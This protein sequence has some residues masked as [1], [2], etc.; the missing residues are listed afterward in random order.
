[1]N[2]FNTKTFSYVKEKNIIYEADQLKKDNIRN[3]GNTNTNIIG[4]DDGIWC[5]ISAK[6]QKRSFIQEAKK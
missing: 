3:N 4:S 2:D 1:L 6:N 5:G